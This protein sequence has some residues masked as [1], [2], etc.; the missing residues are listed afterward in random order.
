MSKKQCF[1]KGILSWSGARIP[2][3]VTVF[4][5]YLLAFI[6]ALVFALLEV[7]RVWGLE[8]RIENDAVMTGNSILAEYSLELWE[9]YGL[10]FVDGTYENDDF[11]LSYVEQRGLGFS[12]DNMD[13]HGARTGQIFSQSWNLYGL[14]TVDVEITGYGL[15]TDQEGRAFQE[16]AVRAVESQ[17]T[18]EVLTLL[19]QQIVD[20]EESE[21]P[22][23]EVKETDRELALSDNPIEVAD[24]MKQAGILGYVLD[25]KTVSNKSMNLADTLGYRE[26]E[27]GSFYYQE[28]NTDWRKKLLFRQ[29]LQMY[30]PCYVDT[31]GD[32]ALDYELE[33]IIAGKASDRENVRAIVNRLLAMRELSNLQY[34]QSD[35]E[36]QELILAAATGLAAATL[37]PEL[38]PVYKKGI[39]AAWA[40][41]ESV[42]DVRLLLDGQKV[43]MVKTQEQWHT[44][45]T[46]LGQTS[47]T[48]KQ[49]QGLSYQQ[50]LQILMWA[51]KDGTLSYR[52]M[53][54]IEA[55][56][57]CDMNSQIYRLNGQITY[58][59][60]SLF[61]SLIAIG[62]GQIKQYEFRQS[63]D[64]SYIDE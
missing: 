41:I 28:S 22:A 9:E 14:Q 56:T 4:V 54:L 62:Q 7:S 53:D 50:Y 10:L 57:G 32:H 16:E 15:A 40:Y 35:V 17:F 31:A 34:L 26:L 42:S 51:T 20:K 47:G 37:S 18:E 36:K 55:N 30:F 13:V 5:A 25:E 58:Q 33:Y 49:D 38:I 52:A 44:D 8:Q 29:Y 60:K 63:F 43:K 2:G 64:V 12:A 46:S 59:S 27:S 45:L 6:L 3:S 48:I 61:S 23:V 11:Q 21:L 24:Q 1:G 39:M 19:Y